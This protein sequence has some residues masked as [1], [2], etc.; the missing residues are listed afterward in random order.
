MKREELNKQSEK[1][2]NIYDFVEKAIS[3]WDEEKKENI[4]IHL[5]CLWAVAD[6]A[7]NQGGRRHPLVGSIRNMFRSYGLKIAAEIAELEKKL[8]D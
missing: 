2:G 8:E 1:M 5:V 6:I 4:L 7:E 3:T